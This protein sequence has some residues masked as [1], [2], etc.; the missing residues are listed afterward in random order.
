MFPALT[1]NYLGQGAL[2]LRTPASRESPFFLLLP[3]WA[4]Y[5]TANGIGVA[6]TTRGT[7]IVLAVLS[8]K[9]TKDAPITNALIADTARILAAAGPTDRRR[10]Y[11]RHPPR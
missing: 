2:I 9:T 11:D 1:L 3:D 4:H 5:A 6:W 7:P 8:S 10:P